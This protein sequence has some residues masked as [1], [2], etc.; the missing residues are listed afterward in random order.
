MADLVIVSPEELRELVAG[1]VREAMEQAAS[2][3]LLSPSEA[4]ELLGVSERKLRQLRDQGM[5]H[6][7]LGEQTVRYVATEIMAWSTEAAE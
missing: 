7:R 1:A 6:R 4:A 3:R 2:P 5:P